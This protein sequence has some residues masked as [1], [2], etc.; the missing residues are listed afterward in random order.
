[1]TIFQKLSWMVQMGI[2]DLCGEV[3]H[4]FGISFQK[5]PS[6]S[7]LDK[8]LLQSKSGLSATAMH[9]LGGIGVVPAQVM[10]SL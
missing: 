7:E 1:M 6:L 2:R 8:R 4:P 3:P 10:C 5:R 9:P